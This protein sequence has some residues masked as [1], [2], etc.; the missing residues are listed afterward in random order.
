MEPNP[1]GKRPIHLKMNPTLRKTYSRLLPM[2]FVTPYLRCSVFRLL[3]RTCPLEIAWRGWR[4]IDV[5]YFEKSD[6]SHVRDKFQLKKE[7]D[8]LLYRLEKANTKRRQLL[9]YNEKHHETIV[10]RRRKMWD[11]R[12][13]KAREMTR[14]L[15]LKVAR[16]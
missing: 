4:R 9:K 6:I 13:K 12:R 16:I 14:T 3:S 5:S 10:G 1:P 11:L 7:G 2:R 8:Y 15:R